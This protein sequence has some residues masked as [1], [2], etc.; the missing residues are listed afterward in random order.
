M[1]IFE[2]RE[3]NEVIIRHGNKRLKLTAQEYEYIVAN[4]KAQKLSPNTLFRLVLEDETLD[5]SPSSRERYQ[6]FIAQFLRYT[7]IHEL[8]PEI[9]KKMM[10]KAIQIRRHYYLYTGIIYFCCETGNCKCPKLC[11]FPFRFIDTK[12]LPR[13]EAE[14]R[15][16]RI[17]WESSYS[18]KCV[19]VRLRFTIYAEPRMS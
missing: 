10:R 15:A 12:R 13:D 9:R 17:F 8:N 18:Q 11:E 5:I 19:I 1:I 7:T 6:R 2:D 14:I 4:A 16:Q 3:N